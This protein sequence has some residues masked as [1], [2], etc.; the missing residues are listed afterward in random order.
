VTGGD[1]PSKPPFAGGAPVEPPITPPVVEEPGTKSFGKFLFCMTE[2]IEEV[3]TPAVIER[4][5]SIFENFRERNHCEIV[6]ARKVLT[7]HVFGLIE[8]GQTDE[9]RLVV[10]A[11]TYLKSLEARTASEK[12]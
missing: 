3:L 11:L 8:D 1:T 12:S 6:E 4:A 5:M 10:S 2:L 7:P 9:M